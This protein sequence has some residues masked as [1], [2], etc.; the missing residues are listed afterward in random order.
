M[1]SGGGCKQLNENL[2]IA[3]MVLALP[4]QILSIKI[5]NIQYNKIKWNVDFLNREK[6]NMY[7]CLINIH[8]INTYK[9]YEMV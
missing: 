4:L 1:L 6:N 2:Q 9:I 5:S 3:K 8:F 7:S